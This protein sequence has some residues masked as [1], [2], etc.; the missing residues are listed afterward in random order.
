MSSVRSKSP[1]T[2]ASLTPLSSR[3]PN[4]KTSAPAPPMRRS[5]PLP[6]QDVVAAAAP[7][8]PVRAVIAPQAIRPARALQAVV[9]GRPAQD[10]AP[11]T[12]GERVMAQR[13]EPDFAAIG[14][15]QR[16]DAQ[17]VG[18][19]VQD[20]LGRAD[21]DHRF[22]A[23]GLYAQIRG[24]DTLDRD[25]SLR[26]IEGVPSRCQGGQCARTYGLRIRQR[27]GGG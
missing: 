21:V 4:P 6:A 1:I 18:R 15:D 22:A 5:A 7:E 14:K 24:R 11:S 23:A 8:Q 19:G 17:A 13:A 25:R 26:Q 3:A 10:R 9:L 27:V 16:L 20:Q 2:S 12:G